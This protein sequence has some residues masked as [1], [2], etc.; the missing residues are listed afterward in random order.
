MGTFSQHQWLNLAGPGGHW[1]GPD[2]TSTGTACG[3]IGDTTRARAKLW[4]ARK[5]RV[6]ILY[7]SV[8]GTG[9]G[10]GGVIKS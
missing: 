4:Q 7:S 10:E 3:V 9:A 1:L 6:H 5:V 2:V 8:R